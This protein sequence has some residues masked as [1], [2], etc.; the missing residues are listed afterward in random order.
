MQRA[1]PRR[2]NDVGRLFCWLIQSPFFRPKPPRLKP[3]RARP[4]AHLDN[5][6]KV[7]RL[8]RYPRRM[9]WTIE[10][11]D[12]SG[13]DRIQK[14]PGPIIEEQTFRAYGRSWRV[15]RIDTD[16]LYAHAVPAT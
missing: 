6:P 3:A 9:E 14:R 11:D 10:F 4:S 7:A 12:G 1:A 13:A 15:D 16:N 8:G 5:A 2:P